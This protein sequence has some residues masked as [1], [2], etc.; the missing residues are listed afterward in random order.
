MAQINS[1][2]DS[3]AYTADESRDATKSSV[4]LIESTN[5]VV[6]DGVNVVVS[7]PYAEIGDLVAFDTEAKKAVFVKGST[8][9][10]DVLPAT[11]VPMAVVYARKGDKVLIVALEN[12]KYNGTESIRWAASYEVTL[13][14][15]DLMSGGT[16]VIKIGE[17]GSAEEL[18]VTYDA[19]AS[20]ADIAS[21]V[22]ASLKSGGSKDYSNNSYGGWSANA[23]AGALILS[24]NTNL[25]RYATIGVSSGCEITYP[26]ENINYQNTLTN[27]LIE[28]SSENNRRSNK[29]NS[30]LAGCNIDSFVNN[31]STKGTAAS[32]ITL[33]SSTIINESSFIEE[34]NPELVASYNTYQDYI[35]GEHLLQ[36]PSVYGA[37]AR[38][39]KANTS[40]IG[41]LKFSNA[42]GESVDCYPAAAAAIDYGV[43]VD[44]HTTGFEAGSWW[45]PSVDEV[46]LLFRDRVITSSSEEDDLI[47]RVLYKFGKTN[48]LRSIT[49]LWASC[50]SSVNSA[51]IYLKS[52]GTITSYNKYNAF[53]VRPVSEI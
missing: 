36:Y 28:G 18:S 15:F 14:G 27:I 29:V 32:G 20:L 8:L 4:S 6:Y 24:S 17:E 39:G 16:F 19:G 21:L 1:Y 31:Y 3:A 25:A 2:T 37:A 7:K 34:S 43:V 5:E 30:T 48:T 11:L 10:A 13:S 44:G 53:I 42:Q 35:L 51:F 23:G 50:E 22:N 46:F 12:A 41:S 40:K 47:D 38:D 9:N 52:Q 33:G 49:Y 45:L 26:A